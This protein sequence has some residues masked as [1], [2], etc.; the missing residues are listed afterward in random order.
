MERFF[1]R[2]IGIA[3]VGASHTSGA[4]VTLPVRQAFSR[5]SP[6]EHWPQ[7]LAQTAYY[8]SLPASSG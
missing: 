6:F 2:G 1:R 3:G 8:L 7:A 4:R 5:W